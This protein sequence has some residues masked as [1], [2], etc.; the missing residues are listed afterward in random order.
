MRVV[1]DTN[2]LVSRLLLDNSI[3]GRAVDK[4]LT[5][6]DVVV[7]EST[8][9]ELADV[10]ARD[11]WDRYVSIDDRQE[12]LGRLLQIAT[13]VPVLTEVTDCRDPKDNQF[14]ALALD[15]KADCI[16]SGDRDLLLLNPWRGIKIVTPAD[17]L[18]NTDLS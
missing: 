11:K 5:Q 1:I 14:L 7:S 15:A 2:A 9:E 16:V 8:M 18:E 12:F 4:A 17:Y 10:L 6:A 13:M 3:P